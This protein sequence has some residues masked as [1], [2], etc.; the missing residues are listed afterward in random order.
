MPTVGLYTQEY[1]QRPK[2]ALQCNDDYTP[3][4]NPTLTTQ[5]YLCWKNPYF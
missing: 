5:I 1:L 4:E 2:V 3:G